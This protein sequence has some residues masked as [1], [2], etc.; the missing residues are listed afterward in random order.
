MIPSRAS[1]WSFLISLAIVPLSGP[2]GAEDADLILHNGK[3]VTVDRD[4]SI[5]EALAIRGDRLIRVGT[6]DEVMATRGPETTVID[7]GG[8]T[9]LPGLIDSHTH[10]TGASMTEYDHPIPQMETIADVLDYIQDR[11]E[12]L[13]EG[14]WIVVRQ[15]FI[16]RLKEQRYPSREELDRAAPNN[17][18][19]FSTGPDASL[20]SLALEL[21]GIDKDF[22]PEGPGKVEI[23]WI[24]DDCSSQFDDSMDEIERNE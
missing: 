19:L 13:G 10:P 22:R 15:V 3:V 6:D 16:T 18:V 12:A 1:S 9:V 7:L 11:A 14:E 24:C 2:A 8:K 21:S 23:R 5:A 17:P 20:N 4:F